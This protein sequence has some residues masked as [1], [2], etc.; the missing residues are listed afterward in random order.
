MDAEQQNNLL[1]KA[2]ALLARRPYTR[3][4]MRDKLASLADSSHLES[5]LDR[6]ENLNLLNDAECAYNFALCRIQ[7][8]GWSPAAVR[9]SLLRRQVEPQTIE[10]VLE[11]ARKESG[12]DSILVSYV[13]K[14]CGKRGLPADLKQTRRLVAHLRRR[15]FDEDSILSALKH[16]I[17]AAILQRFETGE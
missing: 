3:G 7:Q 5:L 2:G 15:G 1:K 8:N 17:P 13:R 4:E 6:L 11:R 10:D 16:T 9:K 14:Y 12:G